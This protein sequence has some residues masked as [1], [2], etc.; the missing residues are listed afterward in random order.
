MYPSIGIGRFVLLFR[1]FDCSVLFLF[2]FLMVGCN[3]GPSP[4]V[5]PSVDAASAAANAMELYDLNQDGSIA[6]EELD[7]APALKAA[8]RQL[9]TNGDGRV[10]AL[11]IEERIQAWEDSKVGLAS[12]LCNVEFKGRPLVGAEVVFEVEPYLADYI[13]SAKGKTNKFGK[14]KL[15]IPQDKLPSDAPPGMNFGL[16]RVQITKMDDGKQIIP[17]KYNSETTLGQE[18]SNQDAAY[19]SRIVYKLLAK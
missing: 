16:Y 18:I 9:D 5:P 11:E 4:L 2:L 1:V 3:R 10:N 15:T 13:S 7:A 17:A 8:M 19:N 6:D 12:V 14:A